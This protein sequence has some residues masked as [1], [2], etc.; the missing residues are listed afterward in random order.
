MSPLF[1]GDAPAI[2]VDLTIVVV[3]GA[4]AIWIGSPLVRGIFERIDTRAPLETPVPQRTPGTPGAPEPS[5]TTEGMVLPPRDLAGAR[6]T[7]PTTLVGAA[8]VLRGGEWIGY[9]ERLA[10]FVSIVGG[11]REGIAVALTIKGLARYPDL[12]GGKTAATS[13][14][15]IIGTFASVLFAIACAGTAI[16]LANFAH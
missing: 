3:L 12:A 7:G 13:E 4:M 16:W 2:I 14:R 1:D 15:F 9:L 11:W 8:H 10:V 5:S 6:P